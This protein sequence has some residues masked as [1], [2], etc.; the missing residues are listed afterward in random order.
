MKKFGLIFKL[1]FFNDYFFCEKKKKIKKRYSKL[2]S[3]SSFG[4]ILTI[5][6]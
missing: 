3:F 6:I 5:I 2:N 4:K 1:N